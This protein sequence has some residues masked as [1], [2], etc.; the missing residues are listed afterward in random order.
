MRGDMVNGSWLSALRPV[1]LKS[2]SDDK[3]V[4][5]IL[6][7]EVSCL[8]FKVVNLW[9]S[10]SD[11]EV[12]SLREEIVNSLGVK[13]LVSNDDSFLMELAL[14]EILNNFHRIAKAVSR[15]SKRCENPV[16]RRYEEFVDNPVRNCFQWSGWEYRWKKMDGKVKKMERFAAAMSQLSQELEVLAEREQTMRRMRANPEMRRLRLMELK[17]KV[18]LQRQE[19]KALKDMSPWNR[20]YDYIVRL[21]ARSLFTILE[22]IVHVF[23]NYP[24]M[25]IEQ[26]EDDSERGHSVPHRRTY[27][28]AGP[29]HFYAHQSQ[30]DSDESGIEQ[31]G[32]RHGLNSGHVVMKK[33]QQ[34]LHLEIKQLGFIGSFKGCGLLVTDSPDVPSSRGSTEGGSMR[35]NDHQRKHVVG[36]AKIADNSFLFNRISI[37]S[38]LSINSGARLP[39]PFTLGD[40]AL[41]LHYA[42]VIIL[43]EKIAS[44]P[45]MI[46]SETR[47][48]LYNMLPT[49]IKTALRAKL[50]RGSMRK[51]SSGYDQVVVA[52]ILGWLAPLAHNMMRWHS[53]RNFEKEHATCKANILLVQTL[54]FADRVK[55]EAAI[56]ELLVGLN[57]VC[58]INQQAGS[59]D[60]PEFI[61]TGS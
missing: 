43:I 59:R 18:K 47:D 57:Y 52:Q 53:E 22:R 61:G 41:A 48:D 29:T 45:D 25:P 6:A 42:K 38:K 11:V 27:S 3:A 2:A 60:S 33:Q 30:N 46:H 23:G 4:I 24:Q 32:R 31:L 26:L 37:Y 15:L 51:A 56:V 16:Y 36:K 34:A 5:G 35:A 39:L 12:M 40:A 20:S 28:F 1:S 10:L 54:Y 58:R 55:A 14:N 7:S 49:T 17:N 9:N 19:I 13:M 21:L 50:K 8:M 44:S